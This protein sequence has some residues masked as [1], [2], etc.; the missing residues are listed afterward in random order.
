MSLKV[1]KLLYSIP[2][3]EGYSFGPVPL[4]DSCFRML[5]AAVQAVPAV[6]I[7]LQY[8]DC[9]SVGKPDES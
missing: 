4:S 9:Y 2:T 8:S 3:R 6:Y 5:R 1:E 7:L